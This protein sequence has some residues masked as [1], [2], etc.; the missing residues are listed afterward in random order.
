MLYQKVNSIHIC[1]KTYFGHKNNIMVSFILVG[2]LKY[3]GRFYSNTV[4]RNGL[5]YLH[6]RD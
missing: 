6:G 2:A 4:N 1:K 5:T 3:S